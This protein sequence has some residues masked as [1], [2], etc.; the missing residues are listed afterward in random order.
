VVLLTLQTLSEA[1]ATIKDNIPTPSSLDGLIDEARL[2][3]ET[4]VAPQIVVG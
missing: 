2:T 3:G 4:P 1:D